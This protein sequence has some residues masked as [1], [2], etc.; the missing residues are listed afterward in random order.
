MKAELK[1]KL[2]LEKRVALQDVIPL[3]TPFL[4]YVDPSSACNFRCQFCPT[5]HKDLVNNSDYLRSIMDLELF[6][7]L[8]KD[9]SVFPNPLKVMRMNKIGEPLLNK[10]LAEMIYLAKDSGNVEYVDLATNGALFSQN[11]LARMVEA[12]LDRLNISLEGI[13]E[14]QYKKHAKVN[15]DF[16]EMVE[17]IKWLYA[18]KGGCEIT[19]KVPGNYLD[20]EQKEYFFNLFGDYCDRIFVE[21]LAP[22]WPEFDVENRAGFSISIDKGQYKQSLEEK[23][24]CTYIFYAMAVNADGSVSACCPDWDQKLI[25]GDLKNQSLNEI[26]HSEKMNSLRKLH[27]ENSRWSNPICRDCGHIKY[28]QLDNIDTYRDRILKNLVKG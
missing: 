25:I 23:S 17:N 27:L 21:E 12:G 22:I 19:I 8:L 10:N 11:L 2:N 4:L 26:W 5:G 15:I 16:Q 13:N 18:N 24:V 7:K 1:S 3:E 14:E 20:D 9:L 28:A 6:K